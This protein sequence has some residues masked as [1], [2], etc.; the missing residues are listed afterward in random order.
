MRH[1]LFG[2][3][4]GVQDREIAVGVFRL[5]PPAGASGNAGRNFPV[6]QGDVCYVCGLS[7][8]RSRWWIG[9]SMGDKERRA[10]SFKRSLENA[11]YSVTWK[12]KKTD[13]EWATAAE[14]PVVA[15]DMLLVIFRA[16][17]GVPAHPVL[18][19]AGWDMQ[20][21]DLLIEF[22]EDLHINRYRNLSLATPWAPALPWSKTYLC[23]AVAREDMCLKAGSH[24]GEMGQPVVEQDVRRL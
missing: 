2:E 22:D 17:G 9:C 24:G 19:P 10:R 11:G 21:D 18:A 4:S 3:E 6:C 16:L 1:G 14:M 7:A 20:A 15:A 23:Y 5:G 13:A 8:R 12:P